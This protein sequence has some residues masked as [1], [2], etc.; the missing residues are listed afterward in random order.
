MKIYL[1]A[2]LLC[3]TQILYP[4]N[5][6]IF[7]RAGEKAFN[8]AS[9]LNSIGDDTKAG[10]ALNLLEILGSID[11]LEFDSALFSGNLDCSMELLAKKSL[12]DSIFVKYLLDYRIFFEPP[13]SYKQ[14]LKEFF[15]SE[16]AI[17]E[18]AITTARVINDWTRS[19]LLTDSFNLLG[20]GRSVM[21]IFYEKSATERE[22]NIFIVAALRSLGFP[23]RLVFLP[24]GTKIEKS[25]E[26]IEIYVPNSWV[27]FY[28]DDASFSGDFTYP[29]EKY[30]VS[31]VYAF[32]AGEIEMLT[33]NYALTGTVQVE[34]DSFSTDVCDYSIGI[35]CGGA[36]K[37][38]DYFDFPD[39]ADELFSARLGRGEY[40]FVTGLR[41]ESGSAAVN[42]F[43][44]DVEPGETVK[45]ALEQPEF[46]VI[47]ETDEL[48]PQIFERL[49]ALSLETPCVIICGDVESEPFERMLE[50]ITLEAENVRIYLPDPVLFHSL[51]QEEYE[52][53]IGTDIETPL[54]VG[55]SSDP[56]K[57]F[58]RT[59]F[60]LGIGEKLREWI[61]TLREENR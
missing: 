22:T 21:R 3:M 54:I 39:E 32:G 37:V 41:D 26:W 6:D 55:L 30:G 19:S 61:K 43:T 33:E 59:G 27:P 29:D 25:Y 48:P 50:I 60:N 53:L 46:P 17:S 2:V 14:L 34:P 28:P 56:E 42:M 20:P 15:E 8:V 57:C 10:Y 45:M 36:I 12:P 1:F 18:D 51:E 23:S 58:V 47:R 38:F 44:F 7:E 52:L 49:S 9:F 31:A 35:V 40:L 11:L 5:D 13:S 24:A 16:T 4:S